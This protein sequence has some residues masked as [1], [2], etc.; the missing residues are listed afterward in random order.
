MRLLGGS[1]PHDATPGIDQPELTSLRTMHTVAPTSTP[2]STCLQRPG[3]GYLF[4]GSGAPVLVA[5][6][7]AAS[8]AHLGVFVRSRESTADER[9]M[10]RSRYI[11]VA[12]G[13]SSTNNSRASRVVVTR[14]QII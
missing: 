11:S 1:T 14:A 8:Q 6:A 3:W 7:S 5:C 10:S 2:H 13:R 12:D 4:N 9:G